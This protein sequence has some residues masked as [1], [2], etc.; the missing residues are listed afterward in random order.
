MGLNLFNEPDE[1]R[2]T[3]KQRGH[4]AT[5]GTGPAGETCKTCRHYARIQ[6]ANTY[7]KCRLMEHAWTSG[8]GTD[9]LAGDKACRYW[10]A[11]SK[12]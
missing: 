10:E 7:L 11:K 9:I 1:P 2:R 5:P 6:Y 12:E 4:A 8:P 3:A